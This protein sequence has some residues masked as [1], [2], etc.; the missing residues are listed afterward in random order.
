MVARGLIPGDFFQFAD[1][2][3]L[4]KPRFVAAMRQA[5]RQAGIPEGDYSGHSFR[6]G[7]AT[8]AAHAGIEDSIIQVL[9]RWNSHAFLRYI[10]MERDSLAHFSRPLAS[11]HHR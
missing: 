8:T 6:I 7:A 11:V 3:P 10:Q 9:G 1:Q 2:M 4:T 5:L